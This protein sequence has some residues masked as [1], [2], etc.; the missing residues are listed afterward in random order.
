MAEQT[1]IQMSRE[2][3]VSILEREGYTLQGTWIFRPNQGMLGR[4][5]TEEGIVELN[6]SYLVSLS[7]FE[8]LDRLY[9]LCKDRG[10]SVREKL[11]KESPTYRE[12]SKVREVLSRLEQK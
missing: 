2:E 4:G 9:K 12:V 11:D 1:Q 6:Y 5:L 3:T 8:E 7:D 10:I